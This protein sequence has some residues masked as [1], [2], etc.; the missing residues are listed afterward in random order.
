MKFKKLKR[1]L[2]AAL[3]LVMT[4]S[5][6]TAVAFAAEQDSTEPLYQMY[7]KEDGSFAGINVKTSM[8]G[9]V[10]FGGKADMTEM[11]NVFMMQTIA[12]ET[13][14]DTAEST[15]LFIK[16]KSPDRNLGFR[17]IMQDTDGNYWRTYNGSKNGRNDPFVAEDGTIGSLQMISGQHKFTKTLGTGTWYIP[18][19]AAKDYAKATTVLPSGTKI[20]SVSF[21]LVLTNAGW[22]G[23]ERV[24]V[25]SV[26]TVKVNGANDATATILID[27]ANLTYT[28][29]ADDLTADV[30]LAKPS[31]GKTF[32]SNF[33]VGSEIFD[34]THETSVAAVANSEFS[35]MDGK[36]T[37]R[38][39]DKNGT[40]IK[41]A[42]VLTVKFDRET[43]TYGYFITA[44][45][46]EGYR[47]VSADKELSGSVSNAVSE[48][49]LV[50]E[51]DSS[52]VGSDYEILYG[53]DGSFAGIN[54]KTSLNG[55]IYTGLK[56]DMEEQANVFSLMTVAF[57]TPV[58]SAE[59]AGIFIR[60]S[61]AR[62][63][64]GFTFLLE[65]ED[66]TYYNAYKNGVGKDCF[67]YAD[68][69]SVSLTDKNNQHVFKGE[70]TW[71]IPWNAVSNADGTGTAMVVGTKIKSVSFGMVLTKKDWYA[72]YGVSIGRV[73]A[74]KVNAPGDAVAEILVNP[75]ELTVTADAENTSADVNLSKIE[76]GK[77]IYIRSACKPNGSGGMVVL[78]ASD[79]IAANAIASSEI[80]FCDTF[81]TLKLT[82]GNGN[83][84]A[85]PKTV[86]VSFD[87]E[88]A[89]F[90]YEITPPELFGYGCSS[91]KTDLIGVA[92]RDGGTV[93]TLVYREVYTLT[94]RYEDEDGNAVKETR[95]FSYSYE[96]KGDAVSYEVETP[97]V[98]G[99]DYQSSDGDLNGMLTQNKEITLIYRVRSALD[100]EVIYDE[101]D[102]FVGV[103]IK[104]SMKGALKFSMA[105]GSVATL[106]ENSFGVVAV[107]FNLPQSVDES[108][109][110]LIKLTGPAKA[111]GFR[112]Y[113]LDT[114][115]NLYRSV[116]A[117]GRSDSFVYENGDYNYIEVGSGKWAHVFEAGS[118]T[119]T[120][121]Y[122]W[123]GLVSAKKG[124]PVPA[125]TKI[126]TW[127]FGIDMRSHTWENSG[128]V[129][130]T[131]ATVK[132]EEN[133]V[134]VK[135][136]FDTAEMNYAA[137]AEDTTAD[138]NL[139]DIT[140]G[141]VIAPYASVS[142]GFSVNSPETDTPI[143]IQNW[144]F[145]RKS[146]EITVR[147][148]NEKGRELGTSVSV[149][150]NFEDG[151]YTITPPS[152]MGYTYQS[153]DYPLAG[154][155]TDDMTITLSYAP[156]EYTITLKFMD[157]D[158]NEIADE[159][160]IKVKYN[161][162]YTIEE[163]EIQIDGYTF[164]ESSRRL[165]GTVM[166]DMTIT[167]SYEKKS[168]CGST[169]TSDSLILCLTA[170]VSLTAVAVLYRKRKE[171][172]VD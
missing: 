99:F 88:S 23:V 100:Y 89:S 22:W 171:T 50:Y 6:G 8:A 138:I 12:F 77:T 3:S 59:T 49:T 165:Q 146:Y 115:G 114:D 75:T 154:T 122:P 48:I 71:F 91:A 45:V 19:T 140:K 62:Y 128:I 96:N 112:M 7:Y 95:Y 144:A 170:T 2:V 166:G 106:T 42:S 162:I 11:E 53:A 56:K 153:A 102:N 111:L 164:I 58:D 47:Y 81:L 10:C 155:A 5:V 109:G 127:M 118:V 101:F 129:I 17:F 125:G 123:N 61:G 121:F 25:G 21:G 113:A 136:L 52:V 1:L 126:V 31:N 97:Y 68:G 37:V 139:Y 74:I 116:T 135:K 103:N 33:A 82:D 98:A 168:G 43:M 124:D 64:Y 51:S 54:D 32:Y 108:D 93:V 76:N 9:A 157:Y 161:D 13:P 28:T 55:A 27:A 104:N 72:G 120:M 130:G 79:E 69:S 36:M 134:T 65:G 149:P 85:D 14:I 60:M 90:R 78:T 92:D 131:F 26:G 18:W 150:C 167:L 80:S 34:K 143:T 63:N 141:L 148:L 83:E 46:I 66:G 117:D 41:D 67:V 87:R 160:T 16:L 105:D 73:G 142:G 70:G 30:N 145:S 163:S 84:L 158:E 133:G 35:R 29:D 152:F 20:Q 86:S 132:A 44:P 38:C 151:Q 39:V 172:D 4:L 156:T 57:E 169:V 94:V 15:G 137:N 40:E 147:Y 107:N 159:R 110:L 24:A 119:G